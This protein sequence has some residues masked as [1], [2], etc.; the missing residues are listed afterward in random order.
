MISKQDVLIISSNLPNGMLGMAENPW[1]VDIAADDTRV[2]AVEMKLLK[3]RGLT[4]GVLEAAIIVVR[5]LMMA[6]VVELRTAMFDCDEDTAL[7]LNA[8]DVLAAAALDE[9]DATVVWITTLPGAVC[10][11]E[12]FIAA[13]ELLAGGQ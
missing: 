12:R 8:P 11:V 5:G 4:G 3:L 6:E 13:A 10:E 9:D 7:W 1:L 2:E